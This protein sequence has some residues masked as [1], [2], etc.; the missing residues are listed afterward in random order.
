MA[1]EFHRATP[2]CDRAAAYVRQIVAGQGRS[3]ALPGVRR[4]ARQAGVSMATMWKAVQRLRQEG[5]LRTEHAATRPSGAAVSVDPEPSPPEPSARWQQ[6]RRSLFADLVSGAFVAG[7][8]LPTAKELCVRLGTGHASLRR[9]LSALCDEGRLERA[10]RGYR[11]PDIRAQRAHATVVFVGRTRAMDMLTDLAPRSQQVWQMLERRCARANVRLQVACVEDI[12]EGGLS[13]SGPVLGYVV[14]NLDIDDHSAQRLLSWL[15]ATRAPVALVD[16]LGT[17]PA[18]KWAVERGRVRVFS[19]A[20]SNAAGR[21]AAD[22]LLRMGHRQAAVVNPYHDAPWALNRVRG[23]EQSFREAGLENGVHTCTLDRFPDDF[24]L[25]DQAKRH[26]AFRPLARSLDTF[27]RA[28]N[29]EGETAETDFARDPAFGYVIRQVLEGALR[30]VFREI[31]RRRTSTAV[32]G[33]TDGVAVAALRC[34]GDARI[35]VP[36][37]VSVLGFD[38]SFDATVHDLTSFDFNVAALVDALLGHVLRP[39]RRKVHSGPVEIPGM[40]V[41]RGSVAQVR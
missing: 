26:A 21:R 40:M 16:E 12:L 29:P 34:L 5:V 2:A 38:N 24:A 39:E 18:A 9:A 36:S 8:A 41:V 27:R 3:A 35:D 31:A 6:V 4:L 23:I 10:G 33:I 14:R 37:R 30:P 20:H 13:H 19:L 7:A 1:P 32:V 17:L 25:R 11:A 15:S 22:L 28:V